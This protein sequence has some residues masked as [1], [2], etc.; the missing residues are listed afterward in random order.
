MVLKEMLSG[1]GQIFS[2]PFKSLDLLWLIVPLFLMWIVLEVYF[3]KHKKE[4]LGWNTAL[5][6]GI[7]LGWLSLQS[8]RYLFSI[9]ADGFWLRFVV[10]I[11]I[12][13]YAIL[14]IYFS[15]SHKISEKWDFWLASPTP[16]YFLGM[17]AIIW[18]FGLLAV[19]W[20]VLLDLLILF[21]VIVIL[22]RIFRHFVKPAID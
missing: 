20:W 16:V 22:L 1:F 6:N 4:K 13:L 14:I 8:M 15:F 12:L 7:T 17:F 18:G 9:E 2:A 10:N 11:V 21:I 19:T 5:A 3:A